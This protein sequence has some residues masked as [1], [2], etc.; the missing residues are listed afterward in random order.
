MAAKCYSCSNGI[1]NSEFITCAGVCGENFHT[2]C[3]SVN[4]AMLNAVTNCPNI[5]WYCHDCN[6]GKRHIS[7]TINGIND[8]IARLSSSLSKDLKQFL[9]GLNL[10]MANILGSIGTMNT[11]RNV[12]DLSDLPNDTSQLGKDHQKQ[13]KHA[14]VPDCHSKVVPDP[15]FVVDSLPL[16]HTDCHYHSKSVV[17]S[18]I[19]KDVTMDYLK[20]YLVD[21][22]GI[23]KEMINLSLLLPTGRTMQDV[24]FIQY[25][26][27]IP[28]ANYSSI[29]SPVIWPKDVRVRDFIHK[30]RKNIGIAKQSFLEMTTS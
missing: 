11:V 29:L 27:T 4:K 26:V 19:G 18:N 3:V 24:N 10:L 20:N 25:K 13:Y 16:S 21:K 28:D 6:D 17:V 2:K 8:A 5:H 23:E 30:Q 15:N 12:S 14:D 22:L 9:D 7:A 1:M